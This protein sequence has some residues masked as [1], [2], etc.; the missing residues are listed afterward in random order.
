MFFQLLITSFVLF[1]LVAV[2]VFLA[3]P[4][5]EI[6]TTI[7]EVELPKDLDAYLE[8]SE[9]KYDD[10]TPGTEKKIFWA[11]EA[12]KKT[13][14]SVVYIHGFT[15]TRQESVPL[16]EIVA[17]QLGAN[18]FYTRLTGHGRDSEAMLEGSVHTW[19]NDANEALEIGRR[20]GNKVVVI[21]MSAGGA[22]A[23]WLATQ[24]AAKD[25]KAFVL[26]SPS[27]RILDRDSRFLLWPWG[28]QIAEL[29]VGKEICRKSINL[30]H[31]RYWT[32]CYPSRALL[33]LK[34]LIGYVRTINLNAI[35]TPM[36]M[37]ISPQDKVVDVRGTVSIFERLNNDKKELVEFEDTQDP[38]HHNLAGDILSPG[39]TE[40]IANIILNFIR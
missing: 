37:I 25:V 4:K 16:S 14:L 39:S 34:A 26:I 6:D 15:A 33:P 22:L 3:G 13:S 27:F 17:K 21:G 11:A 29:V 1:L 38:H 8:N 18:L 7:N 2:V 40:K 20:I 9:S 19:L 31:E 36:L 23:F 24:P 10:I 35:K 32:H 12:G 5:V 30:E 28:G